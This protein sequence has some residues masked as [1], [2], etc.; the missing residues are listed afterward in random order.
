MKFNWNTVRSGMAFMNRGK[1]CWFVGKHFN[2]DEL[3][4]LT[5]DRYMGGFGGFYQEYK[6]QLVRAPEH[7]I[8]VAS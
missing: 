7:D 3:V 1:K 4:V 2:A 8:E 6:S 5:N